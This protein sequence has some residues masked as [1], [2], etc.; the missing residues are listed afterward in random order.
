MLEKIPD[1]IGHALQGQRAGID[2]VIFRRLVERECA[3]LQIHSTAFK[4]MEAIPVQYTADGE[5]ISPPLAWS[6]VT[7]ASREVLLVVEDADSP[8][9][10]PLVHAIAV[11]P[12]M[13][14]AVGGGALPSPDHA[15]LG[16]ATG[17]NSFLQHRWLPPDPPPGHGV[18]R[19]VFQVFALGDGEGTSAARLSAD[20]GRHA[21]EE[22]VAARAIG[23][24]WLIGTYERPQRQAA[25]K[26]VAITADAA[27]GEAAEPQDTAGAGVVA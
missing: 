22:A 14:G 15:G 27:D 2:A 19:Y 13:D 25:A 18:H 9:P 23:A 17:L 24:G 10:H 3:P 8:T 16:V 26:G 7:D 20:L 5:G 1:S 6:G 12:G 11:M 21:V 4:N